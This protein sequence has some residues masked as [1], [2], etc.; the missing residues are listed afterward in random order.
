MEKINAWEDC[1]SWEERPKTLQE[2]LRILADWFD[3]VYQDAGKNDA[4]QQ[5]LRKWAYEVDTLLQAVRALVEAGNQAVT[6]M[7]AMN[8]RSE[9]LSLMEKFARLHFLLES[10]DKLKQ[11]IAA[12]E[13]HFSNK[14]S[15]P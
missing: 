15:Q 1:V 8:E 9:A 2:G 11:A 10:Y 5:D 4:V 7:S 14:T 13:R 3:A 12:V 6:A